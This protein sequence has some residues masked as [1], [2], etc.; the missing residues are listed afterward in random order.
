MDNG[1]AE[2]K[3]DGTTIHVELEDVK[4]YYGDTVHYLLT[5]EGHVRITDNKGMR[6]ITIK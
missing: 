6:S 1:L 4:K 5:K 2:K 3:E